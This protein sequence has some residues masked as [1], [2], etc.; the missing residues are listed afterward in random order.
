MAADPADW[1]L[2][3]AKVNLTLHLC[4]QRSDGYHL[5][6]SVVVFPG[7]GDRIWAEPGRGL[8]L[9]LSGPFGQGLSSGED[10][11]VLR[12]VS[13]LQRHAGA[14]TGL[15]LHLEK[16]LPVA[17]GI[18]GGS[19]DAATALGLAARHWNTVVPD[20]LMLA[21]GADVP[22]CAAAPQAQRMQGIGESVTPIVNMPDFWMVLV[23]P[24]IG[25]PTGAVFSGVADRNPASGPALPSEGFATFPHL[26]DWLTTQRNDLQAAACAICPV[27]GEVLAAL[28][29]AP[30]ARMSGSGATCFALFEDRA[31]AI[32]MADRLRAETPWWV[33]AA[34]VGPDTGHVLPRA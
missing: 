16:N 29:P 17:S 27:I 18:G 33:V 5:L 3:R 28:A 6:D 34:P 23:N 12:A 2:A 31:R 19:S 26:R 7:I 20:D 1:Q 13:A 32:L 15:S 21:I 14:G 9:T 10:N 8:S 24:L 22:V 25:V 30:F 11:L 4:G